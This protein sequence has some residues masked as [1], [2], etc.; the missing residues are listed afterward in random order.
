MLRVRPVEHQ[1]PSSSSNAP[2][3]E[4]SG[5]VIKY[6]PSSVTYGQRFKDAL[7]VADQRVTRLLVDDYPLLRGVLFAV[8]LAALA[9]CVWAFF[10]QPLLWGKRK[11]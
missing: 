4:H 8:V 1:A 3:G 10:I 2:A 5:A 6:D 7:V 11:K 9:A